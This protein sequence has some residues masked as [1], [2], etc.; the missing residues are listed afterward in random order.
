[1]HAHSCHAAVGEATL[2][3]LGKG[4][5]FLPA[6]LPLLVFS[7]GLQH[8]TLP[9]ASRS[10]DAPR[11]GNLFIFQKPLCFARTP[12]VQLQA[13]LILLAHFCSSLQ[14]H[15]FLTTWAFKVFEY[16]QTC[17]YSNLQKLTLCLSVAGEC[18]DPHST[19]SCEFSSFI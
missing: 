18:P 19:F 2:G 17:H 14:S 1:M 10:D 4:G 11:K 9:P 6:A 12:Q 13:C 8:S 7:P 16:I 5:L 3:S 15:C